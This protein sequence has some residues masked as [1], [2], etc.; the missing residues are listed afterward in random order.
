VIVTASPALRMV[1]SVQVTVVFAPAARPSTATVPVV[2][3]TLN[4][5]ANAPASAVP[6]FVIFAV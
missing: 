6:M 3:L 1:S 4:S 2:P 5:T